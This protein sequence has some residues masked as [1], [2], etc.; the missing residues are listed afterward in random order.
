[1]WENRAVP[2]V[3]A[4]VSLHALGKNHLDI[5]LC[6]RLPV[7][8]QANSR[9][10]MK[11][12]VSKVWQKHKRKK[13]SYFFKTYALNVAITIFFNISLSG[14]DCYEGL[15]TTKHTF[16]LEMYNQ[17][18]WWAEGIHGSGRQA[19][20]IYRFLPVLV[21]LSSYKGLPTQ[22]FLSPHGQKCVQTLYETFNL[23]IM[24]V[25]VRKPLST[26][27]TF[28]SKRKRFLNP[29]GSKIW[30]MGEK[31]STSHAEEFQIMSGYSPL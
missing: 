15:E 27:P 4:E 18:V 2:S 17:D 14:W 16:C 28:K 19:T 20:I 8:N 23:D 1:M 9:I 10:S 5:L 3:T 13:L 26:V 29:F 6:T 11:M 25:L 31:R 24:P 7:L 30:P 12:H 22:S 21:I